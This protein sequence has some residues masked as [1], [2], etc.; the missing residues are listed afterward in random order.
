M[1]QGN[2]LKLE[3]HTVLLFSLGL[4]PKFEDAPR[5]FEELK[6]WLPKQKSKINPE[7]GIE[8]LVWRD[9]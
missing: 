1:I 8:G 3:K 5:T 9:L 4:A 2:E 7:V 6:I